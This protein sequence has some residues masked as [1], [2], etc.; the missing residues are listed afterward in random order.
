MRFSVYCLTFC[1]EFYNH[2]ILKTKQQNIWIEEK[3]IIRI[4]FNPGLPL[5]GFRTIL[6]G[7]RQVNLTWARVSIENQHLVSG[8][9]QK[10]RDLESCTLEPAIW[11]RDTGQKISC[12]ERCQLIIT[13]MS[14]IKEVNGKPGL[15]VSVN[16]LFEVLPPSCAIPSPSPSSSSSSWSCVRAREQYR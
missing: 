13:G 7:F 14:N 1:F 12:F 6:P 16:L 9:L 3:V 11:S 8:Q 15:H 2:H 4:N 5:T 10:K